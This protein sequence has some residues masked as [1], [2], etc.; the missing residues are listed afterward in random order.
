MVLLEQLNKDGSTIVKVTHD[1]RYTRSAN[2]QIQLLDGQILT[3]QQKQ[4]LQG[5]A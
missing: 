1:S 2:R 4:Q 5:V 3:E